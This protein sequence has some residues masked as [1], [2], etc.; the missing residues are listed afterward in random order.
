LR[1]FQ[2]NQ[3]KSLEIWSLNDV[4]NCAFNETNLLLALQ[5][6]SA[7]FDRVTEELLVTGLMASRPL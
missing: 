5:K 6:Y 7:N 1:I 3:L 4:K 2:A